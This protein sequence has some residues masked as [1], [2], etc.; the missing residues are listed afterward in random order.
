MFESSV[1]LHWLVALHRCYPLKYCTGRIMK[2]QL[3]TTCF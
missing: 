2:E 3:F 1:H